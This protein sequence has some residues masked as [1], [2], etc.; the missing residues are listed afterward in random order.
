MHRRPPFL[1]FLLLVPMLI[2]TSAAA[3]ITVDQHNPT[4]PNN[5]PLCLWVNISG[6]FFNGI[7]VVSPNNNV[8]LD[9]I[10]PGDALS[11]AVGTWSYAFPP[12]NGF[13]LRGGP[14]GSLVDDLDVHVFVSGPPSQPLLSPTTPAGYVEVSVL[15]HTLAGTTE[16]V[17]S[18]R[19][20]FATAVPEPSTTMTLL[21]GLSYVLFHRMRRRASPRSRRV[22]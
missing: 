16:I 15:N 17:D 5:A 6:V 4:C 8:S 18:A 11:G 20:E 9:Y 2:F 19:L 12:P 10:I 21:A 7:R 1:R 14:G 13:E 3:T 22:R